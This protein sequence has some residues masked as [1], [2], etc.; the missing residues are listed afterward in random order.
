[1]GEHTSR[2]ADRGGANRLVVVLVAVIVLLL[3]GAGGMVYYLTSQMTKMQQ[4]MARVQRAALQPTPTPAPSQPASAKL[5][6]EDIAAIVQAVMSQIQ[7][8][9]TPPS[10]P[11]APAAAPAAPAKPSSAASDTDLESVIDVLSSVDADR[12]EEQPL[13]IAP[14]STETLAQTHAG[15]VDR[16]I[17]DT[18]NKVVVT[19]DG[20]DALAQLG[21]EIDQI[22]QSDT[23]PTSGY[24]QTM[25]NEVAERQNAM[26]TIVVQEGDTLISLAKKAYGDGHKY[27]RILRAN[28]G[29]IKNPDRIFVGQVL[30]VPR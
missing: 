7:K 15:S 11:P 21:K 27:T 23:P 3:I 4:Q 5:A 17:Q 26:R 19:D 16:P 29:I 24:E 12:V 20:S 30:R 8:P 9:P 1:M 14:E 22:V 13:E 18:F 2:S 10:A 28:P 6:T 25:E